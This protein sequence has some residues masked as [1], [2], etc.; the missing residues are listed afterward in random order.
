MKSFFKSRAAMVVLGTAVFFPALAK[1]NIDTI[2]DSNSSVWGAAGAEFL[3]YKE[4]VTP[5]PNSQTGWIPSFAAGG[6]YM[7]DSKWLFGGDASVSLGSDL[8]KGALVL[9]GGSQVPYQGNTRATIVTVNGKVGRGFALTR[10]LMATPYLDVGFRFWKRN[11]GD[12]QREEYHHVESLLGGMLQYSPTSKLVFSGYGGIGATFGTHMRSYIQTS[13]GTSQ[14]QFSLGPTVIYKIG[15]KIGYDITRRFEIFSTLDF[16]HFRYAHSPAV[17]DSS[18]GNY[19][20]EPGS[21]TNET[22]ARVGLAYHL[23]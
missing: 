19:Y 18:D 17:Y 7:T 3:N 20:Y 14:L 10:S 8:Y 23:K 13:T 1:A 4:A 5:I 22:T 21:F 11:L 9:G 15:G 12:G 6:S 16:K 2:I